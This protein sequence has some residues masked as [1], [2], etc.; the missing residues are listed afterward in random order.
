MPIATPEQYLAMIAFAQQHA[1]AFPAVNVTS[2][3]TLNAVL[4]GFADKRSD[5]IIQVSLGGAKF[6]S[7][8]D[9]KDAVLGAIVLA[10]AARRLADKYDVL[11]AL[12]TDHCPPKKSHCV[13]CKA[14]RRAPRYPEHPP[15]RYS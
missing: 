7:G 13:F 2:I 9:V 11:V 14:R 12:H 5:G 1:F 15:W 10:D 6:I 3:T 8:L 4:K